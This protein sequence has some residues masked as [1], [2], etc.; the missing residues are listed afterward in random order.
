MTPISQ[1][2]HTVGYLPHQT[3]ICGKAGTSDGHQNLSSPYGTELS[4]L[5]ATLYIL[6][7]TCQ[8]TYI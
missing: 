5:V 6:Y 7:K 8:Y 3:I 4:G 1:S 2:E